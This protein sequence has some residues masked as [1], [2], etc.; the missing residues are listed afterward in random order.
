MKSTLRDKIVK[1]IVTDGNARSA[2]QLAAQFKTTLNSV[3]TTIHNLRT[4]GVSIAVER[5]VDS[6]GRRVNFYVGA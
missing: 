6:K 4:D 1:T 5:S 3:R 2:K